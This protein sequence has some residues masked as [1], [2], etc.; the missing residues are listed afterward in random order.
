ME[1]FAKSSPRP[2]EEGWCHQWSVMLIKQNVTRK[3]FHFSGAVCALRSR[4]SRVWLCDPTDCSPPGSSVHG[5]LQARMLEWVAVPSSRG[6]SQPS[7]RTCIFYVS[8][9]GRWVLFHYCHLG[10]PTFVVFFPK[11]SSSLLPSRLLRSKTSDNTKLKKYKQCCDEHWGARVSFRS[12]FP[13]A[14][15]QKWDCW[16]I[17]QFY[18]QFFK[19]YPH[20]SP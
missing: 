17:W 10:S 8:C 13:G 18:F 6:S 1:K 7:D 5:I 14:Y 20:C 9:F 12:G 15:A 11:R 19:K 16:V 2:D 4:F 3:A